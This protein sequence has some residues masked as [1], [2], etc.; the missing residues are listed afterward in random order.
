MEADDESL[1]G[2]DV[3]VSSDRKWV[4]IGGYS[5]F[6]FRYV[7]ATF[8]SAF[9]GY[10]AYVVAACSVVAVP[11]LLYLDHLRPIEAYQILCRVGYLHHSQC[12]RFSFFIRC[13]VADN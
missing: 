12:A 3:P 9:F 11:Y 5:V 13:F 2:S 6:F 4:L 8:L 7:V 10:C 1:L